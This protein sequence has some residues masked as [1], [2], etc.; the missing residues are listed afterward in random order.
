MVRKPKQSPHYFSP[1]EASPLV[2][3]TPSKQVR[4]AMGVILPT[5]MKIR[6]YCSHC[7]LGGAR[8]L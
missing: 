3:A 7:A 1:E 4:V 6:W 5:G 8:R 2:T